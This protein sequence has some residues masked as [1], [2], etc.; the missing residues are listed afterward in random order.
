MKKQELEKAEASLLQAKTFVEAAEFL[1]Y[2]E[3]IRNKALLNMEKL[4]NNHEEYVILAGN[5]PDKKT[6]QKFLAKGL[7][8]AETVRD[9][10]G[11]INASFS[12]TAA[13]DSGMIIFMIDK[14]VILSE[15]PDDLKL[16]YN[17]MEQEIGNRDVRTSDKIK[18]KSAIIESF[19]KNSHVSFFGK[20]ALFDLIKVED[21]IAS[22]E[23]SEL[24][25]ASM[26]IESIRETTRQTPGCREQSI[27]EDLCQGK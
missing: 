2:P 7:G 6:A 27:I 24:L 8:T 5:H 14:A 13:F 23:A 16:I 18:I 4:A 20:S 10:L 17:F 19:A 11:T 26:I 22:W 9:C 3:E 12:N 15:R 21:T 1:S 25:K